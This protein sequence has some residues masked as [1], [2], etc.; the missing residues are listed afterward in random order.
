MHV[1]MEDV[2]QSHTV[3]SFELNYMKNAIRVVRDL[4]D[5]TVRC[6]KESLTE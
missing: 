4:D 6:P 1:E 5:L 3:E 2:H